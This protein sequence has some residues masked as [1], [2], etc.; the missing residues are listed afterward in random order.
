MRMRQ[1]REPATRASTRCRP[2]SRRTRAPQS[3][4]GNWQE[5]DIALDVRPPP[6]NPGR[7]VNR[8]MGKPESQL[9]ERHDASDFQTKVQSMVNPAVNADAKS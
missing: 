8:V 7:M 2:A 9:H 4:I 3:A 5:I 1:P 6:E